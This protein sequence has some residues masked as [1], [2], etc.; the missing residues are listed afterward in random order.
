MMSCS[1]YMAIL[2]LNQSFQNKKSD[3][4]FEGEASSYDD[5]HEGNCLHERIV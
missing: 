1:I 4:Q 2:I 5:W 3:F